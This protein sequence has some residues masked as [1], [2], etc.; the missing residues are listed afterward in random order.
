MVIKLAG[1]K[2]VELEEKVDSTLIGGY[3]LRVGD[4]QIDGSIRNQLN[5][6][7]MALLN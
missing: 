7:R 1:S 3:I 2:S 4:R 6:M 5:E